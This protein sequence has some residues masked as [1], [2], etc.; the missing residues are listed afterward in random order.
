DEEQEKDQRSRKL[1]LATALAAPRP[2]TGFPAE[3]PHPMSSPPTPVPTDI[4]PLDRWL[5][6]VFFSAALGLRILYAGH[7]RVDSDEPQHL[8]VVWA[9]AGGLLPYRDVFDNHTPVF[10]A[11]CAPLFHALGVRADILAPMRLAMLPLFAL[12]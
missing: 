3:F 1:L 8:H 12:T 4:T 11:L 7:F 10:Q 2:L 6:L 5:A 9:W